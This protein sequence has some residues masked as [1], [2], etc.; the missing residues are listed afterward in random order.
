[1]LSLDWNLLWTCINLIIFFILMK[2][3][4]WNKIL[5]VME[6]RK[7]AIDKQLKDADDTVCDANELKADYEK[8]MSDV[9]EETSRMIEDAKLTAGAKADKIVTQ[10]QNTSDKIIK[11][12][13]DSIEH[14][15]Q[16]VLCSAKQDITSLAFTTASKI[17]GKEI[18]EP[19]NSAVYD[20]FLNEYDGG[21]DEE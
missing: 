1:M 2:I 16:E 8:K 19:D 5:G 15:R 17:I 20:E 12:A 4:V 3:F 7:E 9:S 14:E 11:D 18:S 6:A 21:G 10:A 13:R